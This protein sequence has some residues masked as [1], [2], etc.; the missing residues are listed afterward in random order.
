[1]YT[2]GTGSFINAF[3]NSG[4]FYV[5]LS[6]FIYRNNYVPESSSIYVDII[7]VTYQI[8]RKFGECTGVKKIFKDFLNGMEFYHVCFSWINTNT[9]LFGE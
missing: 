9:K 7:F 1:M 6:L 3:H 8:T 2:S 5:I 4:Y